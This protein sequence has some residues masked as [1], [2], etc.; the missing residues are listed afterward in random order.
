MSVTTA[1][2]GAPVGLRASYTVGGALAGPPARVATAGAGTTVCVEDLF[3]NAPARRKA[4]ASP[5]DEAARIVD[6]VARYAAHRAGVAFALRRQGAVKP[7]VLTRGGA[8]TT[9]LDALRAVYGAP[10][11]RALLPFEFREGGGARRPRAAAAAATAP[12]RRSRPRPP[13]L[14]PPASSRPPTSPPVARPSS[15]S[16][17]GAPLSRAP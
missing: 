7:D 1:T 4:L 14:P 3:F 5:S 9:R 17:T 11:A 10:L 15:C 16:S 6:L 12:P 8:D 13:P 2:A